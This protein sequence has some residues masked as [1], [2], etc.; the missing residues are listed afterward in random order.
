VW[1][2]ITRCTGKHRKLKISNT[3]HIQN[4]SGINSGAPVGKYLLYMRAP[5]VLPRV[6]EFIRKERNYDR[7]NRS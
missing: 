7:I 1:L 5:T 6:N 2:K 3:I 4:K